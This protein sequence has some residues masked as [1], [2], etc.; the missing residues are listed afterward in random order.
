M[1]KSCTPSFKVI[2]YSTVLCLNAEPVVSTTEQTC[3][4][5]TCLHPAGTP[6]VHVAVYLRC[7]N[8]N[9]ML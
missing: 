2:D 4:L 8:T 3:H 9:Q 6:E 7:Q 5:G 1:N